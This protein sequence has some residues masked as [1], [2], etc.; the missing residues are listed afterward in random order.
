MTRRGFW[1]SSASAIVLGVERP[2]IVVAMRLYRKPMSDPGSMD[3]TAP[4][5]RGDARE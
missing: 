1:W 4:V 2:K 5:L 3:A